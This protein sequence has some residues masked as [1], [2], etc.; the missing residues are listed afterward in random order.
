[1]QTPPDPVV[2][3]LERREVSREAG[4]GATSIEVELVEAAA[5]RPAGR[6]QRAEATGAGITGR[7][8]DGFRNETLAPCDCADDVEHSVHGVAQRFG[9]KIFGGAEEEHLQESSSD[10][11]QRTERLIKM[12]WEDLLPRH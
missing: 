4:H 8:A 3:A 7:D 12:A 5:H 6:D 10:F 11:F 1:M 9:T 2:H